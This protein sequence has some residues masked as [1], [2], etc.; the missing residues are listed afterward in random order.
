MVSGMNIPIFANFLINIMETS[1]CN[2][3][4]FVVFD[5]EEDS[6]DQDFLLDRERFLHVVVEVS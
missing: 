2:F 5:D 3:L 6:G 1:D 4:V